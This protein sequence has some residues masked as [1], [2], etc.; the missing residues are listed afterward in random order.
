MGEE[1]LD[2]IIAACLS[3][4]M[5]RGSEEDW[6]GDRWKGIAGEEAGRSGMRHFFANFRSHRSA[7][8]AREAAMNSASALERRV[9][10]L[11]V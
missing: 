4:L 2:V 10:M 11:T 6:S 5:V 3:M 8:A 1:E 9:R 7:R